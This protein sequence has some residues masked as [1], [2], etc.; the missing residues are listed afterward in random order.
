[1]TDDALHFFAEVRV[2]SCPSKP[3]LEGMLGAVLGISEP[4]DTETPVDYG[5][6]LD[7]YD[8]LV[9]FRREQIAPTGRDRMR[10]DYY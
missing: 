1:M 10:E 9:S 6:M 3:E 2:A 8:R 5:V 4:R 7:D